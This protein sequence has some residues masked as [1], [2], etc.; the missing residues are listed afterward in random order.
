MTCILISDVAYGEANG[1]PLLLDILR[2]DPVPEASMPV[3]MEIHAGAW[4]YGEKYPERNRPFAEQGYF[5]V[6]VN[7]RLSG[8]AI[9]PAPL[10]DL[11]LALTWLRNHTDEYHLDAERIGVWGVSSG[12]H[13]AALLGTTSDVQAVATLSGPS[14]LL[15]MATNPFLPALLGGPVL[16]RQ[17]LARKASP[18]TYV[19]ASAPPFLIMHGTTDQTVPFAQAVLLRDALQKVGAEVTF[20]PF[21]G[22]GHFPAIPTPEFYPPMID[23]FSKHL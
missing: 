18:V 17:E 4:A 20:I 14:D 8:E 19:H 12:G 15:A 22:A 7:Y 11:K 2:P 21:E 16:E 10:D 1:K 13:L 5:T 9:F 6:S 3:I 23:F